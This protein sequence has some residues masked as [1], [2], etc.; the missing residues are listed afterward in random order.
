MDEEIL[1]F[2]GQLNLAEA[3]KKTQFKKDENK[4]RSKKWSRS[5]S[6]SSSCD[7]GEFVRLWY[8]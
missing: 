8:Y 7:E 5:Q 2:G 4:P 6:D 1:T 3:L